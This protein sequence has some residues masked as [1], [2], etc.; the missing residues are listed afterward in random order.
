[1]YSESK[2]IKTIERTEIKKLLNRFFEGETILQEERMLQTYFNSKH[3]ANDLK[4]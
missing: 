1:M 3:V 4:T 2:K